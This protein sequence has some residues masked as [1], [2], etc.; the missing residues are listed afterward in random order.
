MQL[1]QPS[2]LAPL[3][4]LAVVSSAAFAAC[5]PSG[6][7]NPGQVASAS[8]TVAASPAPPPPPPRCA[9]KSPKKITR[10]AYPGA[11]SASVDLARAGGHLYAFVADHD[12]RAIHTVDVEAMRQIA[13]TPLEG[14]PGHVLVLADGRV[15]VTLRDKGD[16]LLFEA[17][18]DALQKPLEERC[19][20]N[21][22]AVEPWALAENGD[23]L[24]V[25]SGFGAA[26]TVLNAGDLGVARVVPLAREP[27]A[28]L[29][30]NQGKTAFVAH[31]VG[32]IVSSID[33]ENAESKPETASLEAGRRVM[34]NLAGFDNKNLR[35]GT[36]GYSL[37]R[38]DGTRKDGTRDALRIFAP[39]ANVDP[40]AA[41][42]VTTAGYGGTGQGPR[43]I[44]QLVSVI[45]P[46]EK[47]SITN[48]VAGMFNSATAQD[49][50]LPRSAAA[51]DKSLF[52]ACIDIDAVVEYDPWVG[53]PTVA[54]KRRFAMPAGPGGLSIDD[55][56]KNVVVWSEFDR[57]I[58][59]IDREK[60]ELK[61]LVMWQRAGET[62]DPK[63]DRG[64]RIFFTSRDAR[65]TQGR[66]CA[67]CHPDGRDDGLVW[68]SPDGKR[69][70]MMLAGRIEGTAPYGWFGEHKDA[71][72]HVKETLKR[73]GGTGLDNPASVDDFDALLAFVSSIP[74]PPTT[75]P[76]DPDLVKRGKELYVS[77]ACETCHKNGGTDKTPHDVGSGIQGERSAFFDTPS[78]IG[79]RGSAPYFH[80]G[81]YATLDELLSE[82]NQRMFSGV[83]SGAEKAALIAYLETL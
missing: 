48:H 56:G 21:V 77:Y 47:K 17:A 24:L 74:A 9:A 42:S 23:K 15:A 33:L 31:A 50:V 5:N 32:G 71:R 45:D 18:D 57:A 20:T 61:S 78:L 7:S 49:C 29:V 35:K 75:K 52:V 22:A 55:G 14:R 41:A 25:S 34:P 66:A 11:A 63:M 73:L 3:A 80:D 81:R 54:E 62:R 64:R 37:A 19:K 6:S 51:D 70:T 12:E 60:G 40:G 83:I 39:H 76:T 46:V 67:N 68:S 2:H 82:K 1:R 8:V 10:A 28:V 65:L 26:L 13:V 27:R 16:V 58:S 72:I 79:L 59:S 69:Q 53:D 4:V 30:V 43:A 38:V 36:Q 44:A